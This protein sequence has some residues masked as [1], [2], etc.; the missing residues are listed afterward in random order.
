MDEGK[1]YDKINW[2]ITITTSI[3]AV[4]L[5][6]IFHLRDLSFS[7][8]AIGGV[9]SIALKTIDFVAKQPKWKK[10]AAFVNYSLLLFLL[11]GLIIFDL[12]MFVQLKKLDQSLT[13]YLI[14]TIPAV[15][16]FTIMFFIIK[17]TINSEE[18]NDEL[19]QKHEA[20]EK[21]FIT[22]L[23]SI[24]VNT[25]LLLK[26][27]GITKFNDLL[28]IIE[29]KKA[30]VL[31]VTGNLLGL[32]TA[33]GSDLLMQ[34]LGYNPS[35]KVHLVIPESS[36]VYLKEL[37]NNV[38]Q[39]NL[40]D[41]INV[42]IYEKL[43]FLQGIAIIGR[44]QEGFT[45][46]MEPIGFFYYKIKS[47]LSDETPDEGIY[48]DLNNF[49]RLDEHREAVSAY[50]FLLETLQY[51]RPPFQVQKVFKKDGRPYNS[52]IIEKIDWATV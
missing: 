32:K 10:I 35:N 2:L 25:G 29:E 22:I 42:S 48:V 14:I 5:G 15:V 37:K 7:F 34:F 52:K 38:S 31:T 11:G 6:V 19:K 12:G 47:S 4:I 30:N 24:E 36:R 33:E 27:S 39:N 8:L 16:I 44:F 46:E 28:K 3:I 21:E 50:Y 41:R 51:S 9:V 17:H 20:K 23:K 26:R 1:K 45:Y 18:E 13:L 43:W 40:L 49:E